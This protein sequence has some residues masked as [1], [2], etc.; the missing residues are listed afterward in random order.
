MFSMKLLPTSSGLKIQ[1]HGEN[2]ERDKRKGAPWLWANKFGD[3]W[4]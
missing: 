1:S 4:P 2:A 3:P